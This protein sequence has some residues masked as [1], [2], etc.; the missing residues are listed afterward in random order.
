M[1]FSP[2]DARKYNPL[3]KQDRHA[4]MWSDLVNS[5]IKKGRPEM[6]AIDEANSAINMDIT[7]SRV[8]SQDFGKP[9]QGEH[10]GFEPQ[11]GGQLPPASGDKQG[12][13]TQDQAVYPLGPETYQVGIPLGQLPGEEQAP[14][15]S[16]PPG[17]RPESRAVP[18]RP[19]NQDIYYDEPITDP[20]TPTRVE[21][22]PAVMPA[23]T[24]RLG[25]SRVPPPVPAPSE[26]IQE[27][28]PEPKNI[29]DLE[30]E[31]NAQRRKAPIKEKQMIP[32]EPT[33]P[34]DRTKVGT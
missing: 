28:F 16:P 6:K 12:R 20:K 13:M 24:G 29:N 4:Q 3:I 23:P 33:S 30:R 9:L 32:G 21:G 10:E 27:R 34:F 8:S 15:K 14:P 31:L 22:A 17:R 5:A 25:P 11:R 2:N 7:R 18:E 26:V 1:P 19:Y